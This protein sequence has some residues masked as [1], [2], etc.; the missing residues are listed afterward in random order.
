MAFPLVL[1]AIG[2]E[3]IAWSSSWIFY[4]ALAPA[5]LLYAIAEGLRAARSR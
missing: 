2:L 4:F 5:A 1:V 3:E